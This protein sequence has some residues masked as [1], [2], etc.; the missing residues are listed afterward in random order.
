MNNIVHPLQIGS[1]T[2]KNNLILGPMAGVCD[3]S[4]REL[5]AA[6]KVG[7][8]CTEMVSAK[9]IMYN[10]KNT[11]ELMRI[12]QTEDV[13]SL[14]IFGSDPHCMAEAAKRIEDI[15]FDIL[16]INMGCPV[17]KVVNNGDGSALLKN[18]KL[19]GRI[20]SEVSSAINK[21]VTVKIRS[22]F[23]PDAINA[24]EMAHILEESGA[25]AV[26]VHART[27]EQFYSGKA[28]WE[29]IA[30]VKDAVS[31]P[32]IGNGDIT[33]A[34]DVSKMFEQTKVDGFMIARAARGNP[35]IFSSILSYFE[36]G[37]EPA[38][39]DWLIVRDM[40]LKHAAALIDQKG[41]YIGIREMRKHAAWYTA[42]FKGASKFRG[43]INEVETYADLETLL[44]SF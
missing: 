42:G 17:P 13:V 25:A 26:C 8:T 39:P 19:A 41:E 5:C 44:Y 23:S 33:C 12:G 6:E 16:D 18:P 36:E 29:V 20:V 2:L 40:I 15:D 24:K 37:V 30:S 38:K 4:F 31:I 32:V 22:G 34:D 14:Q 7:M 10:N 3:M 35:W 21:P 1:V 27:R 43:A 9:A 11:Y 28:D